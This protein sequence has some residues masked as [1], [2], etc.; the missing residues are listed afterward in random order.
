MSLS[1]VP[2]PNV[3]VSNTE[4]FAHDVELPA[5]GDDRSLLRCFVLPHRDLR[6][7]LLHGLENDGDNNE[8]TS[9]ADRERLRV[10]D[11]LH[12]EW[13]DGDDPEEERARERDAVHDVLQVARGHR[14]RPNAGN[15]PALFLKVF[16]DPLRI[17]RHRR[18]EVGEQH[19]EKEVEESVEEAA[20]E[21]C[22]NPLCDRRDRGVLR[23]GEELGDDSREEENREGKDNRDHAG[24]VH[25]ER[26]VRRNST[27]EPSATHALRVAYGDIPLSFR[28]KDDACGDDNPDR[29]EAEV[30]G[31]VRRIPERHNLLDDLRRA[32]DDPHED[33][34]RG[35]VPKPALADELPEPHE[36]HGTSSD[37]EDRHEKMRRREGNGCADT[38]RPP[39]EK[40]EEPKRLNRGEGNREE[41]RVH[42]DP[43]PASFTFLALQLLETGDNH[44]EELE[45]NRGGN[46]RT[47]PEHGD[48]EVR[49][50]ATREDI[51]NP[52]ELVLRKKLPEIF[53]LDSGNGD[54]RGDTEN[55]K[56]KDDPENPP[57]E[58]RRFPKGEEPREIDHAAA[59]TRRDKLRI[60]ILGLC[61][62][63]LAR[64][65][66]SPPRAQFSLA[67]LPKL[68]TPP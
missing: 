44:R 65:R 46:V 62:L 50:T 61:S 13:K 35:A 52:K 14:P 47:D 41:T 56:K 7:N 26:E 20:I 40:R 49:E 24:L 45:H 16:G 48:R 8:E 9:P 23:G 58:V 59:R 54:M 15:E 17:E 6:I 28:D 42:L 27:E 57:P 5:E 55:D 32:R 39:L 21:E 53:L 33:N 19:D 38:S 34:E 25:P 2:I 3:N 51:Q 22:H 18:V 11:A 1:C 29:E 36:K 64:S 31:D 67:P 66:Q 60:I 68:V 4:L 37:R 30:E 63:E 43:L 10:R 12:E